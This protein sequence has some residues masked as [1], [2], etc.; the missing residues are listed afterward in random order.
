MIVPFRGLVLSP[1]VV[2]WMMGLGVCPIATITV[3]VSISKSE[4]AMGLTPVLPLSSGSVSSMQ[5]QRIA[6]THPFSSP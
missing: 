6:R 3:S 5:V 4:Q 2:L 1:S